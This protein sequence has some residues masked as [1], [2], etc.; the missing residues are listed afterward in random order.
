M[1]EVGSLIRHARSLGARFLLEGDRV[2]VRAP[3]PLPTYLRDMLRVRK[4]D[5]LEYLKRES[6]S[7]SLIHSNDITEYTKHDE[8]MAILLQVEAEGCVFLWSTDRGELIAVYD[9]PTELRSIPSG[10]VPLSRHQFVLE[11]LGKELGS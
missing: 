5:V 8:L 7:E 10:F 3:A 1:T 11:F 9:T 6:T 2:K 4:S